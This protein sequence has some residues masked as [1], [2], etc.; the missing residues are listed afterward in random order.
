MPDYSDSLNPRKA[1]IF[2][3]VHRDVLPW[4]L[5]HGL[6]CKNSPVQAPNYVNIGNAE[7]IDKRSRR[8]VHEPPGGNLSDY[9]PFYFTPFS[10]MMLNIHSGRGGV[11]QRGNDEIVILVSSLRRVAELGLP[12]LFTNAH[13]LPEWVD[14]Y[15]DLDRLTEIDWPILQRRDFSRDADDPRKMERYQAEALIHQHVPVEALIGI[16]CYTEQ[17]KLQIEGQVQARGLGLRIHAKRGWYF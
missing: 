17:L 5:D 15:N 6:H 7:L 14:Y 8:V 12:F 11:R 9:V 10:P 13:A 2:R 1:L 16:V 3:I 4:I